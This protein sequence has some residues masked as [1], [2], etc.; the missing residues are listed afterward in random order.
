[1]VALIVMG[2]VGAKLYSDAKKKSR[3]KEEKAA[4]AEAPHSSPVPAS[5]S[6]PPG[7]GPGPTHISPTSS[8]GSLNF[9]PT[10]PMGISPSGRMGPDRIASFPDPDQD[11]D[12]FFLPMAPVTQSTLGIGDRDV[13]INVN[14]EFVPGSSSSRQDV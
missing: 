7:P 5:P 1:M 14:P 2:T 13:R 12:D 8:A 6:P 11:N 4:N 3:E 10:A 9:L